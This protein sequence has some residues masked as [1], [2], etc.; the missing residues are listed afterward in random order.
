ME[1]MQS[2]TA[3]TDTKQPKDQVYTHRLILDFNYRTPSAYNSTDTQSL[4]SNIQVLHKNNLPQMK[5]RIHH[6]PLRK[7]HRRH[8]LSYFPTFTL[9]PSFEMRAHPRKYTLLS[10]SKK[11]HPFR[12]FFFLSTLLLTSLLLLFPASSPPRLLAKF[13]VSRPHPLS[14]HNLKG[15]QAYRIPPSWNRFHTPWFHPPRV[16][17]LTPS[18]SNHRYLYSSNRIATSDGIGHSMGVINYDFNLALRLNLTYTHRVGEYSSLTVADKSAVERFFAWGDHEV[19]RTKLQKDGCAPQ[20]GQWPN[21]TA[22]DIY[23]C[24]VCERPLINGTLGIK[25][26]VD[27]PPDLVS[28]CRFRGSACD[29]SITQF[30]HKY[31]KPRTIFQTPKQTCSPPVT[32]SNFLLTKSLFYHKYWTRHGHLPWTGH[33][34][35]LHSPRPIRL[36]QH[37]LN[38]AMHVRR[39]DFLEP[40]IQAKR[41]ITRD[42]TFAKVFVSAL[43]IV[44]QVGGPFVKMPITLHIYSEGKLKAK[45]VKSVHSIRMQDQTYYDSHGHPRDADWWKQLILKTPPNPRLTYPTR[46]HERLTVI[47]HISEDTL[48]CLHEMISAD[49]FIGSKSGLSNALVWSI[50]RGISLIPNAGTIDNE[51]GRKGYVCCSVPF[52]NNTGAFLRVL[53]KQYWRAYVQANENSASRA[54]ALFKGV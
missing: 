36:M 26:L 18:Q 25:H 31:N 32:D 29:K 48:R 3:D 30:V 52:N 42:A 38:V 45:Q 37:H 12:T 40:Q 46:L 7:F 44:D 2:T 10:S 50:S 35:S 49:I 51:I 9:N 28:A 15:G 43:S 21:D 4:P 11:K 34:R 20:S 17:L 6:P 41:G 47:L 14:I 53:F 33:S 5:L 16:H 27:I 39:G 24:H 13:S 8:T 19:P 23:R 1:Q 54:I 22:A